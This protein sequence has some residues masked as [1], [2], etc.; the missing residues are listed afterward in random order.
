MIHSGIVQIILTALIKLVWNTKKGTW[1]NCFE[2][3]GKMFLDIERVLVKISE[4][5]P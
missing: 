3:Q 2:Y 1:T 5:Q 4:E